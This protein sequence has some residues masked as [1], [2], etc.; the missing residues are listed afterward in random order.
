M[1]ATIKQV[2]PYPLALRSLI[3][4]ISYKKGWRFHLI[5]DLDRGQGSEGM[6]LVINLHTVNSYD[7]AQQFFVNHYMIVPAASYDER[8]WKR[9]LFEQICLVERH[10]AAE[11]FMI[12][13]SRPYAPNHGPGHD[14]YVTRELGTL[15]DAKT[16]HL[17][18][19]RD[20]K[21]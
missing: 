8:S 3:D 13:E 16:D 20:G 15:E 21:V 4:R 1:A 19:L 17:G 12:D 2:A 10:E 14:P 18:A 9:W 11:F 5:D 6:T 7:P